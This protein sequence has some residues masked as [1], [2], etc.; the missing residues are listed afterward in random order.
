VT[1]PGFGE[2]TSAEGTWHRPTLANFP[3]LNG[4]LP[5]VAFRKLLPLLGF[6][7]K[8][9][10][11]LTRTSPPYTSLFL[12][13]EYFYEGTVKMKKASKKKFRN[14]VT[15]GKLAPPTTQIAPVIKVKKKARGKPFEKGNHYGL[16]SRFRKGE[17]SANP[18]GR[19][20]YKKQNE[21]CRAQLAEVVP[22][23][24]LHAAKLPAHLFG[25]TYAEV[26][27]WVMEQEGIRGNISALAEIADRAEG[28]PGTSLTLD[29][30]QSP[31]DRLIESM[32]A[33]SARLGP[34][35]GSEFVI[36]AR[37]RE[38]RGEPD[39]EDD[40]ADAEATN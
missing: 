25:K 14:S 1:S 24:E 37:L 20:A 2:V 6:R 38:A 4:R 34:P 30:G 36:Q 7:G 33:A 10:G 21:A 35:E 9:F 5:G 18:A 8:N 29:E 39:P 26:N 28:R 23:H 22:S 13:R 31:I 3:A 12:L 32:E 11:L 16:A 15:S 17:P 19:P 27:A 40:D